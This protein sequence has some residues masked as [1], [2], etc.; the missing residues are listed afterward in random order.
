M[1]EEIPGVLRHTVGFGRKRSDGNY[2]GTD[3]TIF[4]QFEM[5]SEAPL[6]DVLQKAD[7]VWDVAAA[8]VFERLGVAYEIDPDSGRVTEDLGARA[9]SE[10]EAAFTAAF[11]AA[12]VPTET[13]SGQGVGQF[14]PFPVDTQDKGQQ[15]ANQSWAKARFASNPEEFYDNRAKKQSGEY[16]PTAP[17]AKHK[18]L[19]I[20]VWPAR[21][22]S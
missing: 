4:L 8:A 18:K 15:D 5:P 20:N 11:E 6:A 12:P 17:D 9:E 14:P 22:R 16:K 3:A 13:P 2:G 21:K 10:A 19:G 7:E 1:S